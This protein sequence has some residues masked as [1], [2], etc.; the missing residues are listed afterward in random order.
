MVIHLKKKKII[1]R[2]GCNNARC[3]NKD[4]FGSVNTLLQD[5][6]NNLDAVII[7][8]GL[9]QSLENEGNDRSEIE[10]PGYQNNLVSLVAKH[11]QNINSENHNSKYIPIVCILIHGG[12]L[13]LGRAAD[14]CDVIIDGWYPGSQG[15]HA[16]AD[17]IFGNYNPAGRTPVTWYKSTKDLPNE[18]EMNWYAGKGISY[19]YFKDDVLYPF[20]YGLSYTTFSYSNLE[21]N[22]THIS[23]IDVNIHGNIH[24]QISYQNN[25]NQNSNNPLNN[26]PVE[27][28]LENVCDYIGV[29]VMVTNT[30][31]RD[32]DEII[33]LYVNHPDATVN[34]PNIRL[35]DFER[36]MIKAGETKLVNLRITPRYRTVVYD[37]KVWYAPN[38]MIEKGRLNIFVGGG[39]PRYFPDHLST[40]LFIPQTVAFNT[41]PNQN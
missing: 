35:A 11:I 32:G 30:G 10:L 18:G 37:S 25:S 34:A 39:Q 31:N 28:I 27:Y 41:C 19:R 16:L 5:H 21:I 20:G 33:Q 1:F 8:L 36:V 23:Q 14:E 29:S 26:I 2:R 15:A 17:V 38:M 40:S 6:S 22:C 13:A 4:G 9:D 12:A 7:T 3:L 24:E